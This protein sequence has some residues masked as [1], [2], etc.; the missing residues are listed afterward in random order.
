[1]ALP[2]SRSLSTF[3]H[4]PPLRIVL[5]VSFVVQVAAAVG[6]TATLSLRSGQQAVNTLAESLSYRAT[7]RIKEHL[8]NYL[9]QPNLL[10]R[11]S[12]SA[13]FHGDLPI[14]DFEALQRH[15]WHQIRASDGITSLY[16]GSE[17][18]TFIGVQERPDG[19]T[20]LW[21]I[22]A[23]SDQQR[24]T[25]QLNER[26]QRGA[27]IA[28]QPYD[29]R[30]RP[31]YQEV[32]RKRHSSWSPIYEFA[33]QD[34]SVLGITLAAPIYGDRGE[35]AGVVAL[36]LT[37]N[38]ISSYLK[39]LSLS[40][41]GQAFIVERSG[42]IVATSTSEPPFVPLPNGEQGRLQATASQDP[43]VQTTAQYL[44]QEFGSLS[45][46][47]SAQQLSFRAQGDRQLV[48]VY[49]FRDGRGLDWLIV[50]VIPESDF[51]GQVAANTRTTLILCLFSLIVAS[52]IAAL[53]AHWVVQP[54][55]RL[56]AAAKDL[57]QGQWDQPMPSGRFEEVAELAIAFDTMA[58]QLKVSF[59]NLQASNADL[60]RVDKL[61]DEFLANTSHELKTP[62]N[63]IIG[64]A[65]S[66]IDGASGPLP[67]RIKGNLAMIAAS[68]RRLSTLVDDI[69]DFSQLRHNRVQLKPRPV[70]VREVTEVVFSLT[71]SLARQKNLQLI[72]A[73]SPYLPPVLAD[74]GRLQQILYNLLGNAI[75]F[76]DYGMIG[77]SAQIMPAPFREGTHG[78]TH[79]TPSPLPAVLATLPL[80]HNEAPDPQPD[81]S[82][83]SLSQ[84]I[85]RRLRSSYKPQPGD[86]L[87]IT[88][89]DTG[90]GIPRD[91][92]DHIFIPFE[93]GD[94]TTSRI[95]GGLGIGLAVTK[96]LVELHGGTITVHSNL[97]VGSQFTFTLPLST[98]EVAP[99]LRDDLPTADQAD[100][101]TPEAT[102]AQLEILNWEALMEKEAEEDDAGSA[103]NG[104]LRHQ[105]LVLVVDDEPV[106]R[107]VIVNY[108]ALNNY[109]I[110]QASNGPEALAMLE[111]GL[112]PDLILL[113]V[114]MPRM[115]G[116]EVCRQ[117]RERYPAYALPI[118]MLTAKNQ[119]ADLVEGLSA[120]AN[121]YLAKPV[122]KEELLARLRTHL[123][124]SKINLSYSR[125]VPQQFLQFLNKD[126][127]V[128]VQLGDQVEQNMSVLFADIQD[129][130]TLSEQLTPAE[131]FGFINAF[132]S[133]MEPI[134]ADHGGFID[135][136][137]GDA[138]MALF[139]RD[140]DDALQAAITMLRRLQEY[141]LERAER[142]RSPIEIG[143]GINTGRLMLGTVG[144]RNRMDGTVI[145]DTV[146]VAARIERMTR[147]YGLNLL[148]SHNTFMELE[149]PNR[150][151]MRVIDRVQMKGKT[152]F[153]TVYEV[154]EADDPKLRKGKVETKTQFE[155]AL[156]LYYQEAYEKAATQFQQCLNH[157][158]KDT[159][160]QVYVQRCHNHLYANSIT[161]RSG[162][163][164]SD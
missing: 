106:N 78:S 105:F 66:L 29:P 143:I 61:K 130:T 84:K 19:R 83:E 27:V 16:F 126:S 132:L 96:Q 72:N 163:G 38:Q 156:L 42:E 73:I 21:E 24:T 18:G 25:Y 99:A 129:F 120:G 81:P 1:M 153:I 115:T 95:Y 137:I 110:T 40:P 51:M 91:R 161:S 74:E 54:I 30:R 121:D 3:F 87:S 88:V 47:D 63:G 44:L 114:M 142:Q 122:S 139:S 154:Y 75:K 64:L 93:Q 97:G 94:G 141:N 11:N 69:L 76:T 82:Q 157:C 17:E 109:R 22:T 28:T 89:S 39:S 112:A 20:V 23:T 4:R 104:D 150:Y 136:Y 32:M 7:T 58:R 155:S 13:I 138:I 53:T 147:A 101:L 6:L 80:T 67:R 45:Q 49:P 131:N 159:V 65:E 48:Q 133:R 103:G 135:K 33:S 119:V 158:P 50:T 134:I 2:S 26:G 55:L 15:F 111:N 162:I 35:L 62:L 92:L 140:A 79:G 36:D 85:T 90:I 59:H 125:F 100:R 107:Q 160:A 60:Q 34:F 68:G 151:G 123:W 118:V 102:A 144:G 14:N 46:V 71:Q 116:Y 128:E 37:L 108:L 152:M 70:G 77:V 145:S 56:N 31:W 41:N 148:I 9:V 149:N 124:L 8:Q 98:L 146:N 5:V 117:V 86:L 164:P 12:R 57:A 52:T 127:I 43:L 10:Q 113:D